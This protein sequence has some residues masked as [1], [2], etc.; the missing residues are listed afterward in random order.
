VLRG[1]T[2]T[3]AVAAALPVGVDEGHGLAV[4]LTRFSRCPGEDGG[5]CREQNFFYFLTIFNLK[6]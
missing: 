2:G 1:G 4:G 6:F 3:R 5:G